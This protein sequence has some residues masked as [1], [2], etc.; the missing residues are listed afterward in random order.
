MMAKIYSIHSQ[1]GT[2][3]DVSV[4]GERVGVLMYERGLRL[5]GEF[6]GVRGR[7]PGESRSF[8]RLLK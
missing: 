7:G 8:S 2:K 1:R 4:C 6:G 3:R 5:D